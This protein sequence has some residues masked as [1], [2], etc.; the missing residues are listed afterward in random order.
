MSVPLLECDECYNEF[1][2]EEDYQKIC[3]PCAD[4]VIAK[5]I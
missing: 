4:E 2:P 5:L 1:A 3:N